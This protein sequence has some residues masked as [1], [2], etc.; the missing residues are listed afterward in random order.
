MG[1][2]EDSQIS[3]GSS[4]PL[5]LTSCVHEG[6][7]RDR[8]WWHVY[9]DNFCAGQRVSGTG[10]FQ[11]GHVLHALVEDVWS[12]SGL[13]SSEKKRVSG[14]ST[15]Q[16]LGAWIDGESHTIS[17]SGERFIRL[18]HV[19]LFLLHGRHLNK[20]AVQ[21][22][23]GRWVHVLQFRRPAM[24][25]LNQ[26][27]KFI[28]QAHPSP[29][30]ILG[31]RQELWKLT[32]ITPLLHTFLGASVDDCATASDASLRG[33]AV[34]I[35]PELTLEG[36]DFV[37]SS[38][39]RSGDVGVVPILVISLFN[40]IG[41]CF[42]VY[43]ILDIRPLG[44]IAVELHKPANRIVERRWPQAKI[45]PDVRLVDAA[46]IKQWHLEYPMAEE[47]HIWAGFPCVDL[48][49]VR[50][51]RQGLQGP[52]SSL[53]FEIP[54]IEDLVKQEF[55]SGVLYK[56]VIENVSSM[57]RSAAEDISKLFGLTPYELDSM[58]AV[59]MRRPRFTWCSE[60]LE[61]AFTDLEITHHSYWKRVHAKSVYPD[62]GQWVEPGWQWMGERHEVPL[63]T[64]MK[65]IVR[66]RPPPQPAGI[67]RC[68]DAT[69]SRWTSDSFRFPPYQY[70][71]E[72]LFWKGE[73]WR[74]ASAEE[75]ELLL[76]Y[77]FG[78]TKLC[79]AASK[80]KE[81]GQQTVEDVRRSLLGDSFSVY[82]FCIPGAA[83]CHR[84]LPRMP[85]GW[86]A[87]RMGMAPGYRAPLCSQAP[88]GRY[89]QY[90]FR[91]Q[92][93]TR[94]FTPSDLNRILLTKTNHTGS[95]VRIATGDV[96]NPKAFPRQG[97]DASWW[98]WQPV[99]RVRWKH[100]DH[101]NPLELRAI[102]LS[103]VHRIRRRSAAN[104]R[105]FHVTDSYVCMSVIGKG[106]SGSH[107]LQ[108][109]LQQLNAHLMAFNLYLII[110]HVESTENPTDH[111]SRA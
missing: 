17:V 111:A 5:F 110:G 33:G 68:T 7:S 74:L 6:L 37:L 101:I 18:V 55:G 88:L 50:A 26:V 1:P 71:P 97:V 66:D 3:R 103:L 23:V 67:R 41:G 51:N 62:P 56:K 25:L 64:C 84:F 21:V 29:A 8:P 108:H 96:L 98:T 13:V 32:L 59:P 65:A 12:R 2:D 87:Q 45:V 82:S 43:D 20:K 75:R 95:D 72:F 30:V 31:T 53:V 24:V 85:Y 14:A 39:V 11:Q 93:M 100:K 94:A 22:V 91:N 104:A 27:W 73:Q 40:G 4:L 92:A 49:R 38:Q 52:A 44:M 42:R 16:E 15:A 81:A 90:G 36:K 77:G 83:L 89:L 86:I 9:L 105:I 35:G 61:D 69:L 34:G 58:D 48:S 60:S 54:R 99:F 102:L 79:M 28:S 109:V 80:Q 57:D 107:K 10:S 76:G 78:H 46:M 63:P 70:S 47:I 19:T 106:R